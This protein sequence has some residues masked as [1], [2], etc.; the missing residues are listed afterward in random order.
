MKT[1]SKEV[2]QAIIAHILDCVMDYE[3]NNF[4]SIEQAKNHVKKEFERVTN[5]PYNLQRLPNNQDRFSDYLCGVPFN[6]LYYNS[7]I[8]DYLNSLGINETGK[9]YSSEKSIKLYHYLIFRE[10][11][12]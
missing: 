3:G 5:Y 7:E 8:S 11:T 9:E 10:V 6:F 12:R 1:N 4:E 2:K